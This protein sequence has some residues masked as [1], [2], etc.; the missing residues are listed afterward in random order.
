ME[1]VG[2]FAG[3][4]VFEL[5][6]LAVDVFKG[7]E[8][9]F[10]EAFVG[11]LGAADDGEFFALGEAFVAVAFIEAEAEEG[12]D[13]LFGGGLG[14]GW[15]RADGTRVNHEG[16]IRDSGPGC[17]SRSEERI[18]KRLKRLRGLRR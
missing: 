9:G 6:A 13:F 11:F 7:F 10:G 14:S 1:E 17:N 18:G 8:D 3:F 15:A 2:E 5:L 4:G 12:A 16:N